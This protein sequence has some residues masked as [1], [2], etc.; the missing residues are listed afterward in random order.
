M[1]EQPMQ[2]RT[3]ARSTVSL[4]EW[5]TDAKARIDAFAAMWRREAVAQP[6]LYPPALE[7]GEWDEQFRCVEGA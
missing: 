2:D 5:V 6:D 1:P 3:D 4:D 7:M